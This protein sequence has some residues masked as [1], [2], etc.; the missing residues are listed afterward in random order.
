M[1]RDLLSHLPVVVSV[2]EHRSFVAAAAALDM[3][4]SAVSHAV[5]AVEARLGEPL[6]ARTTR[7]VSLSEAGA[8]FIASVAPALQDINKAVEGV[9]LD[10]GDV[11]GTLRINVPR[12]AVRMALAPVLARLAELHPRLTVEVH[13]NDAFVDIVEKGFDAGI[14]L[15]DAVQ[16]DMVTVRM[17]PAF[18][19]I[20]VASTGYL[21]GRSRPEHVA[22]L[23]AHNCIGFRL[24][25]SGS[26]YDWDLT[27]GG[28][29]TSFKTTG[30]AVV[31]D[32]SFARDLALAGVGIAYIFKPL[33]RED[34]RAGLLQR[35]LPRVS[36]E[37][38][39]LFLY[40]PQRASLATKLRALID[41]ARNLSST[42]IPLSA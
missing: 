26:L 23:A 18:R 27:E 9:A 2:A 10:R 29:A 28:R 5:R 16:K 14:R 12:V 40:F 30:T 4:P 25:G 37:E 38:T 1:D 31:T 34:I 42:S 3:S 20:L 21:A 39:G 22:D 19:A 17:T 36:N 11:T 6:F 13:T 32:A 15:G 35:V 24:L 7:S 41:V 33:V 8:R